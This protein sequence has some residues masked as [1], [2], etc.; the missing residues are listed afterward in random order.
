[1]KLGFSFKIITPFREVTA[2]RANVRRAVEHGALWRTDHARP[3]QSRCARSPAAKGSPPPP[4]GHAQGG[5]PERSHGAEALDPGRVPGR[6]LRCRGVAHAWGGLFLADR[7]PRPGRPAAAGC[8]TPRDGEGDVTP[9]LDLAD[10]RPLSDLPAGACGR[11]VSVDLAAADRERLEVMGLCSGRTL[12]VVKAGDPLIVRV[13]GSRIGL[14]AALA[15]GVRVRLET[16]PSTPTGEARGGAQDARPVD[17][18]RPAGRPGAAAAA[19]GRPDRQPERGEDHPLQPADRAAGQDGE[20]PGD[21]PGAARGDDP[22]RRRA[23]RHRGPSRPLRPE[24]GQPGRAHRPRPPVRDG[25]EGGRRG[26]DR[27]RGRHQPGPEPLPGRPGA[28]AR[29]PAPR[30]PEHDG[31]RREGRAEHRRLRALARARSSG[32][33]SQRP[34]GRRCRGAP[35][36]PR[37]A[38]SRPASTATAARRTGRLLE[39]PR[40]RPALGPLR[41]GRGR[42]GEGQPGIGRP[43]RRPDRADRPRPDPSVQGTGRLRRGHERGVRRDLRARPVPDGPRSRSPAAPWASWWGARC[44]RATCAASWSTA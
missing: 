2:G 14:A 40:L 44:P 18:R 34:N 36:R 43:L 41:L 38:P 7:G 37:L 21:D 10:A 32:D 17:C 1:M 23:R 19:P 13:L 4:R 12:F 29:D 25:W 6:F 24:R 28:G 8:R 26:G 5:E 30:R 39:L 9:G 35:S 3:E 16:S 20:L 33:R 31:P 42:G 11:V 27:R 15:A 22:P